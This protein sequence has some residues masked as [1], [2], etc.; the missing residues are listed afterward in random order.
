VPKKKKN[1]HFLYIHVQNILVRIVGRV[2][3]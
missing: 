3:T 2:G 1:V